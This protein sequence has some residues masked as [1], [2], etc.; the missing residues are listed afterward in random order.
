MN[1]VSTFIIFFFT[2]S[3][4]F[5][6]ELTQITVTDK[7]YKTGPQRLAE[8]LADSSNS[9]VL[10]GRWDFIQVPLN[11]D[12]KTPASFPL[13]Y[14]LPRELD[15][16]KPTVIFFYGGPGISS[17]YSE[18]EKRLTAFNVLYFDQRGTGFSKP[19]TLE[20]LMNPQNFTSE[21]IARDAAQL[22]RKLGI[23]KATVYGHSYGTIPATIFGNLFPEL[24]TAV[25]LEGTIF[26]GEPNATGSNHRIKI[27]NQTFK[28]LPA[29][30][31]KKVLELSNSKKINEG[32]FGEYAQS[33]MYE[34]NFE[35]ALRSSL[36]E[37]FKI[38]VDLQVLRVNSAMDKEYMHFESSEFGAFMF[39][40][41]ACQ[42][43]SFSKPG[44]SFEALFK[45][46]TL[47]PSSK[48]FS[49]ACSSLPGMRSRVYKATSYPLK[50]PVT[51]I[52]GTHDG[53]TTAESAIMHYKHVAKN[54][55]Q[56]LFRKMGGHNPILG[57]LKYVEETSPQNQCGSP[58]E[59]TKLINQIFSGE[60]VN[61]IEL[62]NAF[63]QKNWTMGQ[64]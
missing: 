58:R 32:W 59:F 15:A 36:I 51:Y 24:T 21:F 56:I 39:H 42:E 49:K 13:F 61:Q 11:Y 2:G 10:K 40:H 30:L 57:C 43:L 35:S 9:G 52:Q 8:F 60:R 33:F 28:N 64:K 5:S 37:L 7:V 63:P 6:K 22:L 26:S 12:P 14:N 27:L 62:D 46:G 44:T 47:I 54:E 41:I 4:G 38:P 18:L 48:P 45:N 23:R 25:I 19:E 20:Q 50:V 53:A 31:Q 1:F 29:E 17:L 3:L 34:N 16:S 55:A